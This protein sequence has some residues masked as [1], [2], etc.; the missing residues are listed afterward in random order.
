[1]NFTTYNIMTGSGF[2]MGFGGDYGMC[3]LTGVV[4]FFIIAFTRK[5]VGEE[6]GIGFF[7]WGAY[8]LGYIVWLITVTLTGS[9]KWSLLGGL[10]GAAIGGFALG[11]FVDTNE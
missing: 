5:W 9:P 7:H 11:Q 6:M 1:M 8:G 3:W 10:I 2:D 4:L